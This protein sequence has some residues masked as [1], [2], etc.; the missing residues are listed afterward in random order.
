MDAAEL[1]RQMLDAI[2]DH[3]EALAQGFDEHP[4]LPMRAG[5][6]ATV[7]RATKPMFR[8]AVEK[9]LAEAASGR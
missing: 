1:Q 4:D 5:E 6:V 7:L 2:D 3:T 9:R 8:E